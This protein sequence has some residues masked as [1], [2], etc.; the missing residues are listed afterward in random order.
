MKA[1]GGEEGASIRNVTLRREI[2]EVIMALFG[3]SSEFNS[4]DP[5][6]TSSDSETDEDLHHGHE[7]DI[8]SSPESVTPPSFSPISSPITLSDDTDI[9]EDTCC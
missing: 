2:K 6:H 7:D 1:L 9:D 4:D 5:L 3:N 8:S